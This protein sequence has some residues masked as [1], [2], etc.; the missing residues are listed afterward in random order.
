MIE[1]C[2]FGAQTWP[3]WTTVMG[4]SI[5]FVGFVILGYE[6]IQTNKRSLLEAKSLAA[7]K[8]LFNTMMIDDGIVGEPNSGKATVEGGVLGRL[9]EAIP[10]R[11]REAGRSRKFILAGIG[12]SGFGVVL[13]IAG[14]LGQ[15]FCN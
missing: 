10:G 9:I 5:E 11:E 3:L 2:K 13:Q 7:E 4:S 6:L 12:I 15:A 1:I 14:A 8:S